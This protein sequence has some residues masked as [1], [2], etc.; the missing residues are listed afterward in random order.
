MYN[1]KYKFAKNAER[2][3]EGE[4]K[5]GKLELLQARRGLE[6]LLSK[7]NYQ[8]ATMYR[9]VY[10]LQSVTGN[11]WRLNYELLIKN[12]SSPLLTRIACSFIE[13]WSH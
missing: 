2:K 11:I 10:K 6:E 12:S 9:Y 3:K 8:L 5:R 13:T 7:S 1:K 4:T